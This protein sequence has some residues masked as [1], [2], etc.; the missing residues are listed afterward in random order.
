MSTSASMMIPKV[1]CSWVLAYSWFSTTC[2][3]RVALQVDDDAHAVA[4]RFVTQVGNSLDLLGAHHFGDAL[5]ELGLVQLVGYLADDDAL[6][7]TAVRGLDVAPR[8]QLQKPR[9][10]W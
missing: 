9:P 1:D 10:V 7:V 4:I 3:N 6:A 2:D 8:A 5:E